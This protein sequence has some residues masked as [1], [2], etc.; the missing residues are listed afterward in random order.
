MKRKRGS[1]VGV[2][3]SFLIFIV[4]ITFIYSALEPAIKSENNKNLFLDNIEKKLIMSFEDNLTVGI[5]KVLTSKS[6]LELSEVNDNFVYVA[7]D[8]ENNQ[9]DIDTIE[10]HVLIGLN[11]NDY[12]KVYASKWFNVSKSSFSSCETFY[13]SFKITRKEIFK[14][15]IQKIINDYNTDYE[16]LKANLGIPEELSFK[17]DFILQNKTEILTNKKIVSDN[18]YSKE[19][20]INYFDESA[21]LKLGKIRL[22]V[23]RNY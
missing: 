11:N 15:K 19:F 2:M 20:L 23:W 16:K 22:Q 3:I 17:F 4:F 6:C 21:N 12:I 18:I 10:G 9:L 13:N 7:K 14:K 5:I 1:H 8:K